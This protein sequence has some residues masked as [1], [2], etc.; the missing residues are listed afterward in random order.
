MPAIRLKQFKV[1]TPALSNTPATSVAASPAI[2]GRTL[3]TIQNT[4][5]NPGLLHFKE[6]VQ[7]DGS[8]I[9]IPAG[10]LV[11]FDQAET[12]PREKVNLGSA[13]LTTWAV[14]EQVTS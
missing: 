5:A 2:D 9:A 11:T 14:V 1:I 13:L 8:D 6:A 3:L 12:C 10:Q 4:G 7:N